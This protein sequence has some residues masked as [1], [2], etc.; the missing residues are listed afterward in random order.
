MDTQTI[1]DAA[2]LYASLGW[3]VLPVL[4]KV[5]QGYEWQLHSTTNNVDALFSRHRFDGVGVQLG[6]KSGIVD[7]ECDSDEAEETLLELLVGE[8]PNTPTFA[9]ARGRHYI[10]RWRAGLPDKAVFKLQGL[11][12]RIGNA[13]AAQSVFPPSNSRVW[14]IE[15][16][17]NVIDFPAWEAVLKQYAEN[18][19]PKKFKPINGSHSPRYND[20]ETLNVP[21]WLAKHGREIIHR[22]NGKDGATRWFIECPNI[23]LH[24]GKNAIRDC[25]IT[26]EQD[27]KL[28]GKCF[29]QS[30]GMDSWDALR[31]AI[32]P[33][34]YEDYHEDEPAENFVHVDFSGLGKDESHVPD[35]Q[36]EHVETLNQT[37]LTF[38]SRK[39]PDECMEPGGIITEIMA[40]NAITAIYPRPELALA[41]ALA[42]MS[43]ITARKVEDRW[44]LRTNAY[45]IGLCNSG[46]GKSHA[47]Q[48]NN[49]ILGTLSRHDLLM[50][51]PK[52]GSGVVSYLR[53]NPAAI[54]QVDELSDWLETMRNPQKSPH[55]FEILSLLKEL[56]SESTNPTWKP[57]A[58]ADAKK[59]PTINNPHLT[60]YGVAPSSQFWQ[61]LTK[62]NL[63]DGLVG[64]LLAIESV[65]ENVSNDNADKIPP[66]DSLLQKIRLWLEFTPGGD[67]AGLNPRAVKLQHT[68]EAWKRYREH[69]KKTEKSRDGE[70]EEAYALWCRTPEK[71]GKLAMLRACSRI[72]PENG[73]L[74]V[75]ELGDVEWAIRLSNW[76]TRNMLERAGLYVAENQVESNLLRV[77]RL[78]ANWTSKNQL[79]RKT[80]FLK[81]RE[82]E[83]LIRDALM[84]ERLE[85][86]QVE[87]DTKIR[88]EYRTIQ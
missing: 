77:L 40:Y 45:F 73:R 58:Y 17:V 38:M 42:M 44:E 18:Q 24:T 9:S 66:D 84:A 54:L 21:R 34:E 86:R 35:M 37:E 70:T 15:P 76:I 2:K 14:E 62:Q 55:T 27:G 5:P 52:S 59:N 82:R 48:V 81:G 85:Q 39:I 83:E 26:Q 22:D 6:Q 19:K 12:F 1:I 11:E 30:C 32:G 33:L 41:G 13:G 49:R 20:G 53:D 46:G 65:G 67:L 68:E 8:I 25:C 28:G 7:I 56:F 47:K 23:N 31:D 72:P 60:F 63:T 74:P 36:I 64:R 75:I 29:H 57:A 88:V 80:Q 87:T 51:K 16:S 43:L 61:S 3:F 50:P 79:T 78:C 4:G 10:F 69:G 71:T